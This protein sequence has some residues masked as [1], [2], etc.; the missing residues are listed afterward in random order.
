M[1]FVNGR[2]FTKKELQQR[3]DKMNIA[4]ENDLPQKEYYIQLYNNAVRDESKRKYIINDGNSANGNNKHFKFKRERMLT[5]K[6]RD[7]AIVKAESIEIIKQQQQTT[8]TNK[9]VCYKTL[10]LAASAVLINKRNDIKD[11]TMRKEK[12]MAYVKVSCVGVWNKV[13]KVVNV[14]RK[15]IEEVL[16]LQRKED[17][18]I[19]SV[20]V[21][22]VVVF[23][24]VMMYKLMKRRCKRNYK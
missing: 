19:W 14:V 15:I 24:G 23:C 4:Y 6:E 20:V 21:G 8:K 22:F 2:N 3:L 12:I 9:D 17:M 18:L 5:V 11:I 16:V 1:I 10:M 7:D 13:M